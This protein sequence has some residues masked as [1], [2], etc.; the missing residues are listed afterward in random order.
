MPFM[1]HP[2]PEVRQ[3]LVR[4]TDALCTW[5]RN[6]GRES[7]LILREVDGFVYRAV[8]GKPDVPNDIEDAQLMKL[9]EGK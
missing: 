4:L 6:T 3:A 1:Q 7:V 8:N 5:E 2:D 9:I